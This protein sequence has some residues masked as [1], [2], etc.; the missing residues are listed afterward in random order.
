AFYALKHYTG[1]TASKVAQ[2]NQRKIL[3]SFILY[4]IP[5]S[6]LNLAAAVS[7]ALT[8]TS[9][10]SD[11]VNKVLLVSRMIEG[12]I[13]QYRTLIISLSTLFALPSYRRAMLRALHLKTTTAKIATIEMRSTAY[14][15]IPSKI[16]SGKHI[17]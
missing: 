11:G 8:L 17:Q 1:K 2:K 6:T 16:A 15:V 5:L 7:C 4:C 9:R 3:V 14:P 10:R 12:W 13:I